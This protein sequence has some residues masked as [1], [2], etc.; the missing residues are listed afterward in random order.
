MNLSNGQRGMVAKEGTA[1]KSLPWEAKGFDSLELPVPG[2][3]R[4]SYKGVIHKGGG[5]INVIS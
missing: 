5:V 4:G 2:H 1:V 3:Q